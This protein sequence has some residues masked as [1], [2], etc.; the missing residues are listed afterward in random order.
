[1]TKA[2]KVLNLFSTLFFAVILL[3]IYSYLPLQVDLNLD[4]FGVIHKQDFFYQVLITFI[5]LNIILRGVIFYGFKS[6]STLLLS[7]ISALI[8]VV[9]FYLTLLIGFI[10]VLNNAAH[11]SPTGFGYL[12]VFGPVLLIAWLSGLFFLIIKKL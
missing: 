11:I 7:W 9:N 6:V 12:N 3:L 2:V 10:G 5:I 1:M 4:R 8:F